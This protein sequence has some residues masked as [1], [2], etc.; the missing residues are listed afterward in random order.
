MVGTGRVLIIGHSATRFAL[1]HLLR[2]APLEDL[3][4]APFDWRPGWLN[5]LPPPSGDKVAPA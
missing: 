4:D 1:D 5:A 2:G 3:V